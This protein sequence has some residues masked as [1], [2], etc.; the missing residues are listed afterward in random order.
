[1]KVTGAR[2]HDLRFP[3]S[4]DLAGSD[5]MHPDPDYSAA[6]VV[7]ETDGDVE[8]H[9]F[10]F[11]IGRGNELCVAAIEA[12][13]HHVVGID[14]RSLATDL[15]PLGRA[16]TGDSQL[17]WLGPEKGVVHLAAGAL[18]NAL[19]DLHAKVE[20][21][22]VWKVLVDMAPAAVVDLVDW[23]YLTD[24]LTPDEALDLLD[25]AAAGRD[26]RERRLMAEGLPAYTTSAGWLGY[27]DEQVQALCR[28]VVAAGFRHVKIKVGA[29]PADDVRRV[30]LVRET[31]GPDVRLSVDA[32]QR[33]EVDQ[34]IEVI[35]ALEP[36]DLAW[37]EEPTSPDDIAGHK[38]IADAVATPIATGEHCQNRVMFKQFLASG[39]M[40]VCQVDACRVAGVNE[41]IAT[42]LLAA[43]FDVPVCPHAGGVGLCE[44]VPHL[45]MFDAVAVGGDDDR[46]VVEFAD[47]LHEH[48][49]DPAVVRGGRY[50]VPSGPGYSSTLRPAAIERYHFPDGPT[51]RTR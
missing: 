20:G 43:T 44:L 22:P 7:L 35:G 15:G 25:R 37:A 28:E 19:W 42:L 14:V 51:W 2:T 45:A 9:G 48:F 40:E 18:L 4:R 41:N 38:A 50:V 16:L 11:T 23:R 3:T 26:E 12:L 21:K 33:W 6:Y 8:G 39:A 36:F 5:A 24:A 47:H 29:D 49:V 31:I 17:R 46:R 27:P 10:T 34:A 30:R 13:A 32:N 1:M